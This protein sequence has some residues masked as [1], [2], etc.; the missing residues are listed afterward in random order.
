MGGSPCT[1]LLVWNS[2]WIPAFAGMTKACIEKKESP[3]LVM[4]VLG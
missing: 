2:R 3:A 1:P 4:E